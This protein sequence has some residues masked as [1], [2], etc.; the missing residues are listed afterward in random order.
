MSNN[1]AFCETI[2]ESYGG[3]QSISYTA[4]R[5][6]PHFT[7][8]CSSHRDSDALAG[9]NIDSYGNSIVGA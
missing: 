2:K 3:A 9:P 6:G 1:V 7:A 8:Q 4:T 5:C